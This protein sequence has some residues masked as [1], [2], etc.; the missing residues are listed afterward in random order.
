MGVQT[1]RLH[2]KRCSMQ[3]GN[4]FC[5]P[6][7]CFVGGKCRR[8]NT[9]HTC[10]QRWLHII[11]G[12]K[13]C[14]QDLGPVDCLDD[15]CICQ[16]HTYF[17]E[18]GVSGRI[19]FSD[20]CVVEEG[21]RLAEDGHTM[22]DETWEHTIPNLGDKTK[23]CKKS[24]CQFKVP[25]FPFNGKKLS[26]EYCVAGGNFVKCQK[27]TPDPEILSAQGDAYEEIPDAESPTVFVWL[28]CGVL[29]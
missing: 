13:Q 18:K 16:P 5:M 7:L 27:Y 3:Y 15:Q 26:P 21:R 19:V 24:C 12:T 29:L 14:S 22:C 28:G 17:V 23:R 4:W 25:A 10:G 8:I 1:R 20:R 11:R 2:S 6:G 9:G